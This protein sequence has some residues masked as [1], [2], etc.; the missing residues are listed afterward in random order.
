[1][2]AVS[3]MSVN[4]RNFIMGGL[5][6]PALASKERTAPRPNLVLIVADGL[7]SWMLGCGGNREIRTPNIDQLAQ[8]GTRFENHF[9]CTPASSPSLATLY[10]G[11]VPRQHGIQD[12][13]T[14]EP[15]ENPPQG[16]AAVPPTF[17]NELLLSDVL[18]GNGY[19]CGFVGHWGLG[20][21]A[22][23]QHGYRFWSACDGP[24][25]YQN[26]R[27]SSNGAVTTESGYLTELL[28]AKARAFLDQQTP[29]KPFLLTVS[30][31][32]PH[33]PYDG[34]PAR[35]YETYA[36]ASFETTGWE[37]AASNALRGKE[38][39]ADTVGNSRK[40]AAAVTAL[41]DQI[42]QL[43][44]KLHQRGLR[45]N[46][47]IV[48]T[49]SSG[50]LLGRH[51]LWS[52][53][54]A[55]NPINMYDETVGTPMIWHWLGQI[56]PQSVR[57]EVVSTYDFVPTVCDLLDLPM[58]AGRNLCGRS[59]VPLL[60]GKPLPKKSPWRH[61]IFGQYRNTEMARDTRFKLV[62]R[63]AGA[64]P[65]ELFDLGVDPREKINQYENPK[66]LNDRDQM[67]RAIDGW[68]KATAG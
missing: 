24:L 53:G 1:M 45:E 4:R 14:G 17:H 18:S 7:G 20:D 36:K 5:A 58:P 19:E 13:L 25:A 47:A 27:I 41:D 55:S 64:G 44:A 35:Y 54:L 51:G 52:D 32:N 62:L 39:L 68:R 2:M 3:A 67:A 60:M 31:P 59:Y 37:R 23:P 40:A 30:Y 15:I 63:N 42:P 43:L 21:D 65:N 38:Y 10:T 12:F 9:A 29:A 6:L 11:R 66:Y 16:Q 26:P 48:V 46:T 22:T 56:P 34:H 50:I 28:T 8:S 33:P 57:P 61:T 49:S